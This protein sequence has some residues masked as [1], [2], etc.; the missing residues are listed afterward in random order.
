LVNADQSKIT[1]NKN[2]NSIAH[3]INEA[4]IRYPFDIGEKDLIQWQNK[5]D[6]LFRGDELLII[7]VLFNLLK[8]ALYYIRVANKGSI[9]I[10]LEHG[11]NINTVHFKDTGQGISP[12]VLPHI[13]DR[14]FSRTHHGTGIGLAFCKLVM[15]SSG[16]DIVCL[17]KEGEFTEFILKFLN[18]PSLRTKEM[19]ADGVKL[20]KI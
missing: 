15:Q 6:F 1:Q 18:D 8:N 2:V 14:F 10:W 5:D 20:K 13:F 9:F 11:E 16:G 17:S 7:H 3:C 12:K 19:K 4:L